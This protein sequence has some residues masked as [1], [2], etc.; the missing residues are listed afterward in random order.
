MSTFWTSR[1][2]PTIDEILN[3]VDMSDGKIREDIN[4]KTQTDHRCFTDGE[5]YVWL[6]IHDG[7]VYTIARYGQNDESFMIDLIENKGT[8][9]IP[10]DELPITPSICLNIERYP[11]EP[12]DLIN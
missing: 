3:L 1:I 6:S 7:K 4:E 10:L 9:E 2:E 12:K 11:T 8:S 5:N